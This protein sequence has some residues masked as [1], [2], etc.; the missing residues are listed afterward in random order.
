MITPHKPP[1][2]NYIET[3]RLILRE[4]LPTDDV[5]MF[6]LDSNTEVHK[7]LGNNPIHTIEQAQEVIRMVRQQYVEN[8]IGRWA[9]IEKQ[10]GEFI[11]WSGLKFIREYEN[12]HINFHDVGYRLLPKYWGKGYAT[13]SAKAAI[14]YGFTQLNLNEIIGTA[15]VENI[16]SRKALEKC[17]LKFVE[18]FMWRNIPCDWLKL[19]REEW[20]KD[21]SK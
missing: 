7:Y 9:A 3:E 5:A 17:G 10:S 12:N 13:E 6:E 15:N 14:E 18:K 11:G 19:T 1:L 8:G 21:Y 16:R 4:L 2:K 20:E